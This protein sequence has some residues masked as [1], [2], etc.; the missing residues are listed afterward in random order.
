VDEAVHAGERD[1]GQV[2]LPADPMAM[3]RS[4]SYLMLLALAAVIGVP[5]SAVAYGFLALASYL[6]KKIFT[7]LPNGLGF[8]SE[9]VWWP[10]SVL[11]A[12]G[13]LTAL[14][15]RYLPGQGGPSPAGGFKMLMEASGLGG[16]MLGLVLVPGLLLNVTVLTAVAAAGLPAQRAIWW[17]A[18]RRGAAAPTRPAENRRSMT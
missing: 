17:R 1:I 5:V 4:R 6:Q 3:P 8:Q 9:P 2:T 18:A 14:A 10:L 7:H 11:S 16:P 15:I 13:A 12:G